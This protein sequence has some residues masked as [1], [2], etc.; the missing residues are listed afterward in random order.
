M[1]SRLVGAFMKN[2]GLIQDGADI[3][4]NLAFFQ[5]SE[6][7]ETAQQVTQKT[8]QG[9][10]TLSNPNGSS[11]QFED[12]FFG[13]KGLKRELIRQGLISEAEVSTP[14]EVI[15]AVRE[16]KMTS[17]EELNNKIRQAQELAKQVARLIR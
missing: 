14:S 1:F 11:V 9:A 8:V 12:N 16:L 10:E 15:R 2:V 13:P 7:E 4:F 6:N 3:P 17:D 5:E